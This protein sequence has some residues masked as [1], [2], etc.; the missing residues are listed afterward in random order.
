MTQRDRANRKRMRRRAAR[1]GIALPV[2]DWET[3]MIAS[4]RNA[5]P[6]LFRVTSRKSRPADPL[7]G[8]PVLDPSLTPWRARA[9]Q[10]LPT[11]PPDDPVEDA[12]QAVRIRSEQSRP[13]DDPL[14]DQ[15][16]MEE[17]PADSSA[18]LATPLPEGLWPLR[19]RQQAQVLYLV[20]GL[21]PR[22]MAPIVNRS[23]GQIQALVSAEGW[24]TERRRMTAEVT[25]A[26]SLRARERVQEVIEAVGALSEQASIATLQ[27]TNEATLRAPS[28]DAAQTVRTYAAASRDLVGVARQARG[29]GDDAPSAIGAAAQFNISLFMLPS[30]EGVRRVE[31]VYPDRDATLIIDAPALDPSLA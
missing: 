22:E 10:G 9:R 27:R 26:V 30:H 15:P 25:E 4:A 31:E 29:L 17:A 23:I 11:A 6:V 1:D 8:P 28:L 5:K 3:E 19:L 14:S 7:M 18:T 12:P 24:F 20:Q 2:E 16:H 13:L 21:A